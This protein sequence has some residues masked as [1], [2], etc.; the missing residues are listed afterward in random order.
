MRIGELASRSG[1]APSAVRYY[2][3]LGLLPEPQRTEAGYRVYADDAID[4]L[5]FIRAAQA[6]GLTLAEVRQV[7]G[8]RDA[9]ELPCRV[10]TNLIE[11]RHDE[12]RAKIVELR[13]LERD[14]AAVRARAATLNPRDCDPSGVCHVIP[15][16][17]GADGSSTAT[18]AL[19]S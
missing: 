12:V 17:T 16:L 7:L 10:V 13:R 15:L 2:E 6:V 5:G 18:D 1:L 14:L 4:R 11:R 9:G 8:V 3:Q 19:R